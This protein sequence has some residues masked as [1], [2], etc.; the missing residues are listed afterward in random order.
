MLGVALLLHSAKSQARDFIYDYWLVPSELVVPAGRS[1]PLMMMD[2]DDFIGHSVIPFAQWN[3]RTFSQLRVLPPGET[4]SPASVP[5]TAAVTLTGSGGHLLTAERNGYATDLRPSR[6]EYFLQREGWT[7]VQADRARRGESGVSGNYRE[8]RYFKALIQVGATRDNTFGLR[9]GHELEL[10]PESDPVFVAAGGVLP[11]QLIFRDAP[12]ANAR[13]VAMSRDGGDPRASSYVSD[14]MGRV[15][16]SIATTGVWLL[17][18]AHM[19]RCEGCADVQWS[20]HSST[21]LFASAD[22]FGAVVRAPVML[23]IHPPRY[24]VWTIVAI[25]TGFAAIFILLAA[26]MIALQR[27]RRRVV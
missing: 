19:V 6:F 1:I 16:V 22:P 9:A 5:P 11:I 24:N 25:C 14:Q 15:Q 2:G 10:V 4:G 17:R 20:A 12:L 13:V 8:H 3:L 27:R 23:G 7:A 26:A 21:Y 18:V